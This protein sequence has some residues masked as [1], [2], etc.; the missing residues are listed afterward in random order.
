M[1]KRGAMGGKK[2]KRGEG[3]ISFFSTGR[4]GEMLFSCILEDRKRL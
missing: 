2:E 4:E 1:Q 3:S